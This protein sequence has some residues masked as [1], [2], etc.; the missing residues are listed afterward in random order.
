MITYNIKK[1]GK[2][3]F[4]YLLKKDKPYPTNNFTNNVNEISM[5]YIYQM[6][7]L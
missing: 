5:C 2:L 6:V 7:T 1:T 3:L 4:D